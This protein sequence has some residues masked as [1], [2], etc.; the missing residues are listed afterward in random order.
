MFIC[1][2]QETAAKLGTSLALACR[3]HQELLLFRQGK[4]GL[5]SGEVFS[6]AAAP[7]LFTLAGRPDLLAAVQRHQTDLSMLDYRGLAEAVAAGPGLER[8]QQLCSEYVETSLVRLAQFRENE[9]AEAI[10][11]IAL[12]ILEE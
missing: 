7:V 12:S 9:A 8:T 6:L 2:N 10:R 11:K 3:A 4:T 1:P 5:E